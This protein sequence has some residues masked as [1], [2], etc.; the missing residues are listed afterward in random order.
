MTARAWAA[1][2]ALVACGCSTLTEVSAGPVV[3]VSKG[4][5]PT[6]GAAADARIGLGFSPTSAT[7]TLGLE[8]VLRGKATKSSQTLGF[9]GGAY[10][11][12][13]FGKGVG[14]P[15]YDARAD[16]SGDDVV[17]ASDFS[18]L[19]SNFGTAGSPGIGPGIG[20]IGPRRMCISRIPPSRA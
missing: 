3:G 2:L 18:L 6:G 4:E 17:N 20:P 14:Q 12:T 13:S 7:D 16:F 8:G 10:V 11:A 15:G 1:T 5:D 19:R 9:G